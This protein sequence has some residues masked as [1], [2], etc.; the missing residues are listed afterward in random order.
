[1]S[2]VKDQFRCNLNGEADS[3]GRLFV[4]PETAQITDL[5]S[6]RVLHVGVDTVRQLYRGVCRSDVLTVLEHSQGLIQLFGYHWFAGRVGRDSGYQYKLQNADL[7]LIL[8][9]K[10]F[11][12]KSD[13][14]GPHLKIEV[15]PHLIREMEPGKLQG[16]MDRLADQLLSQ[17]E[18]NQCA[19]HIAVDVQ[20]WTPPVDLVPR[21]QCR[22][23]LQREFSGVERIEFDERAAVYGR[24]KSFL[25]G[26]AN[27]HQLAIYN[28]TDQAR[29]TDKL[30]FWQ[31][32]W[33]SRDNPFDESDPLNYDPD[34]PVW[35]VEHRFH[36]SVIEQFAQGTCNLRTGEVLNT[37]TYAAIA[38]HLTAIWRYGC[39]AYKLLSWANVYDPFWSLLR[40]DVQVSSACAITPDWE[41]KRRYK[42][43]AGFSGKNVELFLGNFIS[44][45]ARERVGAK[46]AFRALK[47]WDCWNVIREYFELKGKTEH[48]IYHWIRDKLQERTIRWGV[49]V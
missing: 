24:G 33:R 36:H 1:M 42:T 38:P 49:A 46:K 19:V 8:L 44:L 30:D 9:F 21:M 16:L 17:C 35:R 34:C 5:S 6:V 14:A 26:S 2:R 10:N 25:W 40:H 22:S 32:V 12:C 31:D 15:S 27:G 48:D 3:S 13:L 20:G 4:C 47:A 41:Y 45:L 43:A 29:A 37:K 39:T 28:K 18:P 7:G 23:R 11:N